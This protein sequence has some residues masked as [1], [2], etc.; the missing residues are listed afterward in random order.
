MG[1]V[2]LPTQPRPCRLH[3]RCAFAA[4]RPRETEYPPECG[5]WKLA[6]SP[7]GLFNESDGDCSDA[8]GTALGCVRSVQLASTSRRWSGRCRATRSIRAK[9]FGWGFTA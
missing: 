9:R 8:H 1:E 4:W 2:R 7:M 6:H 5:R 3:L